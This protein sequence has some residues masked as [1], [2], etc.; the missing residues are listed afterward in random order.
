MKTYI[1]ELSKLAVK[2]IDAL[3]KVGDED[4]VL[5]F[6][7][8]GENVSIELCK[9][10]SDKKVNMDIIIAD[11]PEEMC[12][13]L[14]RHV[15]EKVEFISAVSIP[16]TVKK[17]ISPQE[18][19]K[20]PRTPRTTATKQAKV[21]MDKQKENVVEKA[22]KEP[23]K[24]TVEKPVVKPT[25]EP[26]KA[27]KMPEK[28]PE[29]TV[30]WMDDSSE[31]FYMTM[32]KYKGEDRDEILPKTAKIFAES[33]D[34]NEGLKKIKAIYGT[35]VA[36]GIAQNANLLMASIKDGYNKKVDKIIY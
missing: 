20:K 5:I 23:I 7:K 11:S 9:A 16:A 28:K 15:S 24:K 3:T 31:S 36:D 1:G 8:K 10:I 27:V 35:E 12:F 33:N 32:C 25:E 18:K 17:L 19:P 34:V 21:K 26:S 14:G 30:V 6:C 4:N 29:P 13:Y 2:D 22:V